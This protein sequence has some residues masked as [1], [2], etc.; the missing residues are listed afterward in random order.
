M[1]LGTMGYTRTVV[2]GDV[3]ILYNSEY[4]GDAI[5]LDVSAFTNGV[6]KAGNGIAKD[7][8]KASVTGGTKGTWSVAIS[9]AFAEDETIVINGVTFTCAATESI[10]DKKFAGAN[11][12][13]Q[14]T[15]LAKMASDE[16]FDVTASSGTLTFTQKEPNASGNAPTATT[17]AT[18]GAIGE[19][20]KGTSAVDGTYDVYGI[21]LHDVY[22]GR[23]QGT[24]VIGGYIDVARAVAHTGNEYNAALMSALKNVEFIDF[25]S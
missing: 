16:N 10:D 6:C 8:K 3:E 13:A 20:T 18:T 21:L 1:A 19:V 2:D 12:T 4:V 9:T 5:T 7:G 24:V 25:R 22:I 17:T 14:G 11:A 23:P 15:S